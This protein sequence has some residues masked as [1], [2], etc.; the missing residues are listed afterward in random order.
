MPCLGDKSGDGQKTAENVW[1]RWAVTNW[2]RLTAHI[3]AEI[4]GGA[5]LRVWGVCEAW[6]VWMNGGKWEDWR[7]QM[8]RQK[9]S[10]NV[11]KI[12]VTLYLVYNFIINK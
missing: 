5:A 4:A 7:R 1:M 6:N 10:V 12:G 3:S 2:T 11:T 9:L 8:D